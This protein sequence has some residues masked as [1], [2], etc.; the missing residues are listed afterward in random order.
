MS[1]DDNRNPQ[2]KNAS[3]SLDLSLM[4]VFASLYVVFVIVFAPASFGAVQI[5]VADALF[6]YQSCM[7]ILLF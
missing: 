1:K 4:T 7:G 5:R 6:P 3:K 2:F